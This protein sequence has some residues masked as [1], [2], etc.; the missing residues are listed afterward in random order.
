MIRKLFMLMYIAIKKKKK[1][2]QL[3]LL[4]LKSK[5]TL[6]TREW[7]D[8]VQ[9]ISR[10]NQTRDKFVC[11]D[12]ICYCLWLSKSLIRI[13]ELSYYGD[14]LWHN[15]EMTLTFNDLYIH[16]RHDDNQCY[17]SVVLVHLHI[18]HRGMK[19]IFKSKLLLNVDMAPEK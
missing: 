8:K 6:E 19:Q 1:K 2:P 15:T 4:S 9:N 10:I 5:I 11:C 13:S 7:I 14:S 12:Q 16:K 18:D 17:I 3:V